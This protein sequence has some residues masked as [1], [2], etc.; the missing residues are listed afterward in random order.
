MK[1]R[2][3][4][5]FIAASLTCACASHDARDR[6]VLGEATAQNIASQSVR[7]DTAPNPRAVESTSGQ[8]AAKAVKALNE[9]E[10]ADLRKAS[11]S[12]STQ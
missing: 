10:A 1:Q 5:A 3:L 2:T 8:R 9:G 7:D 12:G 4:A 6:F 11:A